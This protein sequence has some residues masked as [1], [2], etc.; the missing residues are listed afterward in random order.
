MITSTFCSSLWICSSCAW[1]LLSSRLSTPPPPPPPRPVS[2]PRS[3]WPSPCP[4]SSQ[5]GELRR[6]TRWPTLTPSSSG[7]RGDGEWAREEDPEGGEEGKTKLPPSDRG[8]VWEQKHRILLITLNM[9]HEVMI[10]KLLTHKNLLFHHVFKKQ[11]FVPWGWWG[12]RD[13]R[14][15]ADSMYFDLELAAQVD[16]LDWFWLLSWCWRSLTGCETDY[17]CREKRESRV[18][19]KNP[20]NKCNQGRR[21]TNPLKIPSYFY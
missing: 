7:L 10:Q 18:N 5:P 8:L 6:R 4:L 14:P 12:C 2:P 11:L 19:P 16:P 13:L 20:K 3:S 9:T 1:R 17:C 21:G 15:E